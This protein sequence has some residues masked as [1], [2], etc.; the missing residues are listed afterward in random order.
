[1]KYKF[2]F[3]GKKEDLLDRLVASGADLSRCYVKSYA[4]DNLVELEATEDEYLSICE[5]LGDELYSE[6][7]VSLSRVLVDFLAENNLVMATAESCTGGLIAARIVDAPGAS[8]VFYEGLVTYS[9]GAKA[10]RLDVSYDTLERY[11]AVSEQTAK[12]MAYGLLSENV[13]IAVSTTGVAGPGGGTPDKPV[14]LVYIGIAFQAREP[15]AI[16]CFYEGNR[17]DIRRSATHEA[18][19]RTYAYLYN[20]L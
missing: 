7:D 16:K 5:E 17:N 3:F 15:I 13:D 11:G 10:D 19:Y 12:E 6:G 4:L 8:K 18:L 1:M 9:N 20:T 2:K 14:G